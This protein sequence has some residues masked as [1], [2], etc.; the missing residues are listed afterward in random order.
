MED[1]KPIRVFLEVARQLSFA[2]AARTL[3]LTPATVTRTVAQ[4]EASLGQQLLVRTT[5]QVSMTSAGAMVAARYQPIVE[6]FDRVGAEITRA[7]RP[8]FGRLRVNAPL[9]LGLRV[10]P[11]LVESFRLAYPL[12]DLQ[13]HL[14]DALVDII[15]EDCDLAIRISRQ[16]TDKSTIWRKICEVPRY[17]I[18]APSLFEHT[19]RP[20]HPEDLDPALTLSYSSDGRPEIWEF[21][22]GAQS[23]TLR[24]GR[25]M[26]SNNGDFL[27]QMARTGGGICLLPDFLVHAGLQSGEVIRVL[28]E[29]TLPS[30][31]LTLFYPPYEQLPPLVATFSDFFEAYMREVDGMDFQPLGRARP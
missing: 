25:R 22:K 8:D 11:G 2:G 19:P 24:A 1:L 3:D 17:L 27:Y 5:R 15:S 4:L 7:S 13:V 14:T 10:L 28:P 20:D 31:W 9:S 6:E 23:R 12:I 30:L 18:A 29:W 16:T 26:V 21:R